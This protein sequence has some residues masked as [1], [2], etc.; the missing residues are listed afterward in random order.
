M[1]TDNETT[2]A[3]QLTFSFT[4]SVS[5]PTYL[6][7]LYHIILIIS[8]DFI[9]NSQIYAIIISKLPV[10]KFETATLL[11]RKEARKCKNRRLCVIV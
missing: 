10:T 5:H 4:V 3:F 6:L 1:V 7:V 9:G 8:R 11:E 2:I